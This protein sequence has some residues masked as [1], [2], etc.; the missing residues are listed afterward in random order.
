MKS[1][2]TKNELWNLYEEVVRL[3]N[4]DAAGNGYCEFCGAYENNTH[5]H[6]GVY[7]RKSFPLWFVEENNYICCDE[8]LFQIPEEKIKELK[9]KYKGVKVDYTP[10][11]LEITYNKLAQIIKNHIGWI[12][13]IRV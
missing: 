5:L 4:S 9:K 7:I 11:D 13:K 3:Q 8:C 6:I 12:T 1:T 2:I 10:E